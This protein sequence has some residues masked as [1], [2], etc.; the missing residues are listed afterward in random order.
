M[1]TIDAVLGDLTCERADALVNAAN[2]TLTGGG[3][4][5]GALHLAA[6]P[7]LLQACR[8]VREEAWPEGLP[9]GEAVA[10]GAG[11]LPAKWV[12]H[13]VAPNRHR[14]QLDQGLLSS[15]Y[16]RSLDIAVEL[17]AATVAFPA[18]G[19]GA[20]GWDAPTAAQVA[21][22]A[23]AGHQRTG[24]ERVRFVLFNPSVYSAF[25]DELQRLL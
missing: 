24:I 10:T 2:S 23:V 17:G 21:V 8:K 13:T 9:V 25:V 7:E 12:I 4:V 1:Q 6:G 20:Y 16:T 14:G 18:I 11:E 19:A 15:C 22:L 5:D 3:G